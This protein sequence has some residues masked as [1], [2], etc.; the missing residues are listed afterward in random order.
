MNE[1]DN[2]KSNHRNQL[3][4]GLSAV[5][6]K[7]HRIDCKENLTRETEQE[8][9]HEA[10]RFAESEVASVLPSYLIILNGCGRSC[11]LA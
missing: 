2:L 10:Q 9:I 11:R 4:L 1:S 5:P 7:L 8:H 6:L 3:P